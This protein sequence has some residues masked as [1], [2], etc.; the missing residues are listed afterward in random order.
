MRSIEYMKQDLSIFFC[1]TLNYR[2]KKSMKGIFF[3]DACNI[4]WSFTKQ[5]TSIGK[6]I[7]ELLL[8]VPTP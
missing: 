8:E 1:Q 5:L 7:L 6:V 4:R 3:E 2:L